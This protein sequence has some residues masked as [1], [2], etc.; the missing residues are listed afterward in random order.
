MLRVAKNDEKAFA[1]LYERYRR[2]ILSYL[3][4]FLRTKSVAEELAQ[5]VFL[6][7]YRTRES[8]STEF[9]FSTWIW[10]IARNLAIDHLRKKSEVLVDDDRQEILDGIP[11]DPAAM[12]DAERMLIERATREGLEKCLGELSPPQREAT[13]LRSYSE[14]SY[15]EIADTMRSSVPRIKSLLFRAKEAL[16]DCVKRGGHHE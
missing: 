3:V 2:P 9:R 13:S 5:E 10:T 12:P 7:V 6:R 16:L 11:S 15:E 1:T 4:S 8:Y 14:L